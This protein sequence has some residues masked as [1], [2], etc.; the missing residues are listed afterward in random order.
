VWVV[1]AKK[2]TGIPSLTYDEAVEEALCFGWIDAVR[3][4]IDD[5]FY[6]QWFTPRRPKSIWSKPNKVRAAR[7]IEAGLMTA[8]GLAMIE[9]AK[10]T[11]A[12]KAH[13]HVEALVPP[14]DLQKALDANARASKNWG[15]L[16]PTARKRFLYWLSNVKRE[17]TRAARVQRI[18]RLVAGNQPLTEQLIRK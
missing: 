14:P 2:H 1:F 3:H 9:L 6:K 18:V 5:T 7:L 12:W 15:A 16:K 11:G 10:K 4:P 17:E 8:A 13:D